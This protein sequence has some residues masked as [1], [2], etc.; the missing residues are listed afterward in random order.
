LATRNVHAVRGSLGFLLDFHS[1]FLRDPLSLISPSSTETYLV[2]WK[3]EGSFIFEN[4][5][6]SLPSGGLPLFPSDRHAYSGFADLPFSFAIFFPLPAFSYPPSVT[7]RFLGNGLPRK[8]PSPFQTSLEHLPP[9]SAPPRRVRRPR[10]SIFRALVAS[11][12]TSI[13]FF[14][15]TA[16]LREDYRFFPD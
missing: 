11:Q 1:F 15:V 5:A 12:C 10:N 9:F 16:S 13:T 7:S 6:R 2:P 8:N 14:F 4:R 3:V